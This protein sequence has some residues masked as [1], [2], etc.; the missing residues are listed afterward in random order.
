LA[1][2]SIHTVSCPGPLSCFGSSPEKATATAPLG[3]VNR[4]LL[5]SYCGVN[6]GGEISRMLLGPTS[7]IVSRT[8]ALVWPMRAICL[9]PCLARSMIHSA[10]VLVLPNPR[11][12]R[13]SQQN[14]SPGGGSCFSLAQNCQSW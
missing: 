13:S 6:Q 12:E 8:S 11:P 5:G 14:Q 1:S 10:P 7:I 4:L 2:S 3:Q 9:Y